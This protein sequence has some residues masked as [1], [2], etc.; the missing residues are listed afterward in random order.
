MGITMTQKAFFQRMDE[1]SC[2]C[3]PSGGYVT[4]NQRRTQQNS[5]KLVIPGG[6]SRWNGNC[7]GQSTAV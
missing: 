6:K 5:S 2:R 4:A 3:R 7:L 1:Q